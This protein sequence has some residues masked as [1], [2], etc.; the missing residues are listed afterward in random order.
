M[1]RLLQ[2][3]RPLVRFN[4]SHPFFAIS[5]GLVSAVILAGFAI[6]LKI[7]TDIANLL[8]KS[9]PHVQSLRQ[10]QATLGGETVMQVAIRSPRFE[11][12]IAFAEELIERSLNM[13]DESRN[14]TFF[15][16][17]EFR[18]DTEML[19]DNALW[20]AT[21][22]ELTEITEW[23]EEEIQQAREQANPFFIDF[24][25]DYEDDDIAE[26][27]RNLEDF[28]TAY[29]ELIPSEYPVNED[30][31]L[32]IVSLHPTGSQSNIGYLEDMFEEY[33]NMLGSTEYQTRYPEMEVVFGGRLKR[34]LNEL[35]S[36]MSDVFNSFALGVSSVILL[37]L[38]FFFFK[39][40]M[41]YRRGSRGDQ[42]HTIWSHL[43]RAPIPMM[44]IGIPLVVSLC[45]TFGIAYFVLG[46]LN[47]MTSVLFVILF[48]L[49]IDYGIHYYARYIE[50]RS[51]GQSVQ[52]AL[53]HAY[54]R[55][56]AAIMV[57]SLTT[58]AA[59]FVLT[60]ADFR[61]FSEFGFIAGTGI[62]LALFCMLFMLPSLLTLFERFNWMLLNRRSEA[63]G[64]EARQ[65]RYPFSKAIVAG[66]I[67]LSAAVLFQVNKLEF[68]Y[69]FGELEPE[70]PE[71]EAF[72]DFTSGV[73]ESSRRNPAYILADTDEHLF[74]LVERVR[75]MKETNPETMI[76]DVEALQERFPPSNELVGEKL[77]TISDIRGLL[78]NPFLADQE[79]EDLDLLRRGAGTVTPPDM[80]EIPDFLLN[81]FMT[82]EGELGRFI[83]I[84]P[85]DGLSDGR[86][87]IAFKE[88]IGRIEVSDG[89]A[90]YAAST[91][92]VA[93]E[94]LDLMISESPYMVAITFIIVFAFMRFSFRSFRWS[95]IAMIPLITGL[96]FLF[97]IMLLTG[98]NFNFYNLVVLPA[99][100]GIG[101]DNGV[102]V[103]HRY[104]DEGRN[105]MWDVLSSTGQHISI[106]SLTTMM[107]FAG[108]LFT[109]HPG[110]QSIGLMAVAGIGMTLL[111]ALTLLPA[112]IQIL[113][114]RNWIRF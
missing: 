102:H 78:D 94:M 63:N 17:A 26:P 79:N 21:P 6:Q 61:G 100:L 47:T 64:K 13:R 23:L 54:E 76:L 92:I 53:L 69:Q 33:G 16:R 40:Y 107:G 19:R 98:L 12:N 90:Y 70:F 52:E 81:R 68:E 109:S 51:D 59:L 66:S 8:P 85:N 48:G 36:I 80:E 34:H 83:I 10:L 39:K 56:G 22:G 37:V 20:F 2:F 95:L 1:N 105:S 44:V 60:V 96:L 71:Y 24:S 67:L 50:L 104:L 72:R 101:C 30:S 4:Y 108:L 11:D 31:T 110:L 35:E 14:N 106:G 87:S 58:S 88:E 38:L 62:L 75:E 18:R 99:I 45:W 27:T 5:L 9:N 42:T 57:S 73:D 77:E 111:T 113:G 97:G 7:D 65:W 84:Y 3:L 25:D 28:R 55:T 29:N 74:E 46:T 114:D 86:K 93:A 49:G 41:S 89:Q 32:V 82:R 91:S 15:N 103:A 112:L 43:I